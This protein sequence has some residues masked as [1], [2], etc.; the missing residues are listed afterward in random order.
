MKKIISLILTVVMLASFCITSFALYGAPGS[1]EHI[2]AAIS[3]I[4]EAAKTNYAYNGIKAEE[5]LELVRKY[6]PESTGVRVELSLSGHFFTCKN[7]TEEKEGYAKADFGFY[8]NLKNA[9]TETYELLHTES[10]KFKIAKIVPGAE[11]KKE[12]EKSASGFSD[13]AKDAYYAEPVAWAV[14]KGIT[15]GTSKTTFSPDTTCTRAQ[16]ITFLW[17]Y[18]GSPEQAFTSN[19]YSDVKDSDYY[20]NAA[21]WAS[22]KGMITGNKFDADK[23]CTRSETVKFIWISSGKPGAKAVDKFT[24]IPSGADYKKAVNWAVGL[25]ITSGTSDTTFSPDATCT[26]GQIVTFLH[27]TSQK[28]RKI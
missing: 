4:K 16:I 3:A 24:D 14:E 7:A 19:P 18:N 11:V 25:G 9:D 13:V 23:P 10:I 5:Y 8:W 6:V 21:L 20:Y 12:E 26:R 27:R 2:E 1:N 17:R 15:S 28:V 22:K